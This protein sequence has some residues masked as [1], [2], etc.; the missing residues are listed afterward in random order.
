MWNVTNQAE[1]L[2]FEPFIF[3]EKFNGIQINA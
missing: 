3:G 1:K 2:G